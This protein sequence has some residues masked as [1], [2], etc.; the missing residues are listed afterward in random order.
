MTQNN[1]STEALPARRELYRTSCLAHEQLADVEEILR[2]REKN[3]R[4]EKEADWL[5]G[6]VAEHHHIHERWGGGPRPDG[7]NSV[8][9]TREEA[10]ASWRAEA[11][12]G[13][14]E[15]TCPKN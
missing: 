7:W 8:H 5:A 12:R 2:L 14:E 6:L 13:V 9:D 15:G 1:R 11:R 10:A 4:L 3:A